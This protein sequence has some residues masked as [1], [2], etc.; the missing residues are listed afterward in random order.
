M[1]SLDELISEIAGKSGRSSGDVKELVLEKQAE[2]SGLVSAEG[3]AYIVGRE[4]GVDLI[5][6][7][8][9]N[10]KINNVLPDMRNVDIT[11]VVVSV[12][13]PREYDSKGKKGVVAGVIL[14]DETGTV[15]LPLWNE[16][17]KLISS[18]GISQND[19]VRISGAWA[20]KDSRGGVELRLGRKG[21]LKKL[22]KGEAPEIRTVHSESGRGR[23]HQQE[24]GKRTDIGMV[25]PGENITIK[26]CIV[27]VYKK[28]PYYEV[29]PQCGSRVEER[30]K[31]FVCKEHG[32]VEPSLNL[33]ASGVIDDGTGNIRVVFFRDQAEKLFGKSRD[34]VVRELD[35]DSMDAFWEKF[36]G[37]GKEF[38]VNGRVRINDFTKEPEMIANFVSE[39]SAKDECSRLLK[40]MDS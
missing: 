37:L 29:C 38:I 10:L 26:G 23:D 28:K 30:R 1:L 19:A 36:A 15:R 20:K 6:D 7:S 32:E 17:V 27:Q 40:S 25:S 18:L 4:L 16:E 14:G 24:P 2:L 22:K 5:K 3:A 9:R 8:R 21:M 35:E 13:E 34:D 12:F 39:I 31:T 11:A 33:L